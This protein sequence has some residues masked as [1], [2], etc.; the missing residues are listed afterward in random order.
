MADDKKLTQNAGETTT[1]DI[2]STKHFLQVPFFQ[3]YYRWEPAKI[4]RFQDDVLGVVDRPDDAHFLGAIITALRPK[5]SNVHPNLVEVIDGQ[6]RLTTVYIHLCAVVHELLERDLF[7]EASELFLSCVVQYPYSGQL[8]NVRLHSAGKDR[9]AINEMVDGLLQHKRFQDEHLPSEFKLKKLPTVSGASGSKSKVAPNFRLAKIWLKAQVA[10][11]GIERVR[12]I[13]EALLGNLTVVD[14]LVTSPA[15]GPRIFNSLNSKQEPMSTGDL[16]RND[17]FSRLA[18]SDV[19][20][21]EALD[22]EH[23]SP[24]YKRFDVDQKIDPLFD[25]YFFPFG[26][27]RNPQATTATVYQ[28]LLRDW[29]GK[30]PIQVIAELTVYQDAYLAL[31][32][33]RPLESGPKNLEAAMKKLVDARTPSSIYPFAMRLVVEAQSGGDGDIAVAVQILD[34]LQAFLV[35][36]GL[37][38]KEP[39]GL[40]AVFKKLWADLQD[41]VTPARVAKEIAKHKTVE[42]PT[43]ALLAQQIPTRNAY[44]MKITPFVLREYD[45][46]LQGDDVGMPADI[47]HVLPQNPDKGW[48]SFSKEDRVALTHTLAN[49]IPLTT[50]MNS[51]ASNDSYDAKRLRFKTSAFKTPR[52]LAEDYVIWTPADLAHRAQRL[53]EWALERWPDPFAA[54]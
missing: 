43:D 20:E 36:R 21:L 54:E 1:A 11:Y 6:Q 2:F 45:L 16:V 42:R 12:E 23:W 53:T 17:V 31:A 34:L 39:T 8:S 35:R 15:Q 24:F 3:R 32:S 50:K 37:T 29:Q 26:L 7:G 38:G 41:D 46:S 25:G 44:S 13:R 27:I 14:I 33:S 18:D 40:H 10:E 48:D 52:A 22:E 28:G 51:A 19:S 47:E 9:Q 4:A 30:T 5:P 49:L